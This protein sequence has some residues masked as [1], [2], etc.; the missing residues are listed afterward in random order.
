MNSNVEHYVGFTFGILFF[1][2]SQLIH[3][4]QK[5]IYELNF[6]QKDL[7]GINVSLFA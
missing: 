3:Q 1:F 2:T 6:K 7:R 5:N 4:F